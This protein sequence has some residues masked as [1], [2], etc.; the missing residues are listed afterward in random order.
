MGKLFISCIL[1]SLAYVASYAA[2]VEPSEQVVRIHLKERE[3]STG[4][5]YRYLS[6]MPEVAGYAS[7]FY[8]PLYLL[9]YQLRPE[10]WKPTLYGMS[11]PE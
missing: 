2:L 9:D 10:F 8:R 4:P 7:A 11:K 1:L 5:T 6:D 3:F